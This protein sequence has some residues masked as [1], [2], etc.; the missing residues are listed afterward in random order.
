M[1]KHSRKATPPPRAKTRKSTR[2]TTRAA[3]Q[4]GMN[5]RAVRIAAEVVAAAALLGGIV[6][7]ASAQGSYSAGV[8][9]GL[10]ALGLL[11]GLGLVT[12][13]RPAEVIRRVNR[14]ARR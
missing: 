1:S 5:A 6:L 14:L 8:I 3:R 13:L 7:A 12:A 11:A 10:V 9:V 4:V 2:S